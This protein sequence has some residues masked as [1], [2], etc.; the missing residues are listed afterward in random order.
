M[1]GLVPRPRPAILVQRQRA[2]G[3]EDRDKIAD[4]EAGQRAQAFA[5]AVGIPV[6]AAIPAND[7]I[8][9]KS[10][11]YEIVGRPGGQWAPMFEQLAEQV[12]TAPPLRPTPLS[13]DALL[14]LF[15]GSAVGRDVVLDPATDVDMRGRADVSRPSLEVI[16]DAV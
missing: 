6:L 3:G 16:Y 12:A 2:L 1:A 5:N 8:R 14:G 15:S 7:D 10:A 11:N 4:D 13:H 9:R